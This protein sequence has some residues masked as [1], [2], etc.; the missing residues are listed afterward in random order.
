V[1]CEY[2]QGPRESGLSDHAPVEALFGPAV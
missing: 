2:L 1:A